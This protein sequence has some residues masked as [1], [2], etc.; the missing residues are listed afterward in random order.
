MHSCQIK[1][2]SLP[3]S[4]LF[5]WFLIWSIQIWRSRGP[6]LHED[7]P[8]PMDIL[9]F[10]RQITHQL[11]MLMFSVGRLQGESSLC[12][13][14]SGFFFFPIKGFVLFSLTPT[15]VR[16]HTTA[17]WFW[18]LNKLDSFWFEHGLLW[19]SLIACLSPDYGFCFFCF[20]G[21]YRGCEALLLQHCVWKPFFF[22]FFLVVVSRISF[23]PT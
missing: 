2:T 3:E 12:G 15:W 5:C 19:P 8:G 21:V 6:E 20:W 7:A 1:T 22:F 9:S 4:V 11:L 23:T 18:A 13:S 10:H 14:P 17:A 16:C